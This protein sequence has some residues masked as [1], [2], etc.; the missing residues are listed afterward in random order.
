MSEIGTHVRKA[1][2]R[3]RGA[4]SNASGRYEAEERV[5]VDDGWGDGNRSVESGGACGPA[6][7]RPGLPADPRPGPGESGNFFFR[8]LITVLRPVWNDIVAKPR[9]LRE[10]RRLSRGRVDGADASL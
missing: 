8:R 2:R 7:K 10:T 5:L 4:A 6:G 1:Q 3:G 9:L